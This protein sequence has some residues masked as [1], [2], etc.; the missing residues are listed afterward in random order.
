MTPQKRKAQRPLGKQQ[1]HNPY[2]AIGPPVR[3]AADPGHCEMGHHALR[4]TACASPLPACCLCLRL[5]PAC[6]LTCQDLL[7]ALETEEKGLQSM[8][9]LTVSTLQKL[10][11]CCQQHAAPASCAATFSAQ[12][13]C[14]INAYLPSFLQMEELALKSAIRQERTRLAAAASQQPAEAQEE[15]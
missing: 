9:S 14:T 11:V 8:H 4:V 5:T 7:R 3:A 10:Q 1:P 2:S 6:L 12:A 15:Q 13:H